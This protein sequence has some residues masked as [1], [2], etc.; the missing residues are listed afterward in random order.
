MYNP[1][2]DEGLCA[3][4]AEEPLWEPV[5]PFFT[6]LDIEFQGPRWTRSRVES[7]RGYNRF[8]RVV[9]SRTMSLGSNA[10]C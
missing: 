5:V 4:L 10:T 3:L 7:R 2:C 8:A 6:L 1:Y 9:D